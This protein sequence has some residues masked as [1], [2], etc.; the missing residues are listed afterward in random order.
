MSF[1]EQFWLLDSIKSTDRPSMYKSMI[2]AAA[3]NTQLI[4]VSGWNA[5]AYYRTL[6]WSTSGWT[7][8]DEEL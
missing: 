5:I 6:V 8:R 7:W 3:I 1:I 2:N 4:L